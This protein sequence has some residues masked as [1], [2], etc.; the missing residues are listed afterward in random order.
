MTPVRC[1][2]VG[3]EMSVPSVDV[4][5]YCGDSECD[6]ISCI[7]GLEPDNPDD[8]ETIEEL[9]ALIRRGRLAEHAEHVLAHAEN[10]KCWCQS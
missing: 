3:E 1:K 6:G 7:A 8:H 9:H 10:R 5:A 2:F 4:C